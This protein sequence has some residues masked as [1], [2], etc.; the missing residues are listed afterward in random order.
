[1]KSRKILNFNVFGFELPFMRTEFKLPFGD[2]IGREPNV[3][4]ELPASRVL[5]NFSLEIL[6]STVNYEFIH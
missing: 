5:L 2:R 3:I 6:L 4:H 1:M